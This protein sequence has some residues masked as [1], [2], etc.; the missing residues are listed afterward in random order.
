MFQQGICF[1]SIYLFRVE[2]VFTYKWLITQT[3]AKWHA[4][5]NLTGPT[6]SSLKRGL[7]L[8][9]NK[10]ALGIMRCFTIFQ[11]LDFSIVFACASAFFE[12][13]VVAR[14]A[15]RYQRWYESSKFIRTHPLT[16]MVR[17]M[18]IAHMIHS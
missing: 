3:F 14:I 2:L 15:P 13:M 16:I 5:L 11:T 12:K 4:T 18:D 6:C 8:L 17:I 9:G 10:L 1:P 7:P